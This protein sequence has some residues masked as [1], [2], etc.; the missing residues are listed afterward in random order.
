MK[1][2]GEDNV[3]SRWIKRLSPL[4]REKE[5]ELTQ[6]SAR[7]MFSILRYKDVS[8]E[9]QEEIQNNGFAEFLIYDRGVNNGRN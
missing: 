3:L 1:K 8:K 9:I 7:V 4:H 6:A 5:R 2:I